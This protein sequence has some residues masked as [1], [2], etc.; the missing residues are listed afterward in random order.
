MCKAHEERCPWHSVDLVFESWGEQETCV[1]VCV[2]FGRDERCK[3]LVWSTFGSVW[4]C[5]L[6]VCLGNTLRCTVHTMSNS[7]WKCDRMSQ[8]E[9][10]NVGNKSRPDPVQ[11][12]ISVGYK[13]GLCRK[14]TKLYWTYVQAVGWWK[15]FNSFVSNDHF[16]GPLRGPCGHNEPP[17]HNCYYNRIIA[18]CHGSVAAFVSCS[19][20]CVRN[21]VNSVAFCSHIFGWYLS[22]YFWI[23][24]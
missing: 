20:S 9:S 8:M 11:E 13:R 21:F 22:L 5:I 3:C 12:A 10:I 18:K 17:T 19:L 16:R 24:N 2:F 6:L 4:E 14:A 15:M 1:C 23:L 7:V